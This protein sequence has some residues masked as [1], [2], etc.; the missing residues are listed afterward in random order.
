MLLGL[1]AAAQP[2]AEPEPAPTAAGEPA[3][4]PPAVPAAPPVE[5]PP[6]PPPPFL[7]SVPWQLR[8]LPAP[9]VVRLDSVLGFDEDRLSRRGTTLVSMLTTSAR[10]PGTGPPR[11]GLALVLRSGLVSDSPPGGDPTWVATNLLFGV[12]Y[13]LRLPA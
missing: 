2:D 10:I 3:S 9:T 8:P 13:A 11:A 7:Y 4:P 6:A 1:R 12:A 5:P